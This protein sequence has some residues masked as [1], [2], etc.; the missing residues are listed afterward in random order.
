[1]IRPIVMPTIAVFAVAVTACG[2]ASSTSNT[3]GQ[4]PTVS[5]AIASIPLEPAGLTPVQSPAYRNYAARFV[6][7][8]QHLSPAAAR[9]FAACDTHKIA[10]AGYATVGAADRAKPKDPEKFKRIGQECGLSTP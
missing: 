10:A 9:E 2:S 7:A 5:P 8:R 4:R 1:M 3:A 6:E